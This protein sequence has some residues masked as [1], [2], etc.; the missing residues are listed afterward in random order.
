M[1]SVLAVIC[2]QIVNDRIEV[3][4]VVV[5]GVVFEPR[6]YQAVEE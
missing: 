3:Q 2:S 1:A 5:N 4:Q 6:E